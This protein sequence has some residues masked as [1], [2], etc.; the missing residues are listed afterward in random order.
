MHKTANKSNCTAFRTFFIKKDVSGCIVRSTKII[1]L[2]YQFS[3]VE[4]PRKFV[5]AKLSI[6]GLGSS[7]ELIVL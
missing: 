7:S 1:I 6:R 4:T 2:D 5:I 3:F